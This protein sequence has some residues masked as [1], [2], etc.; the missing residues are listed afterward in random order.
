MA[1]DEFDEV[2]EFGSPWVGAEAEIEAA[3]GDVGPLHEFAG[4]GSDMLTCCQADSRRALRR[5]CLVK[6]QVG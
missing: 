5:V 2:S 3:L 1:P 4:L 6:R